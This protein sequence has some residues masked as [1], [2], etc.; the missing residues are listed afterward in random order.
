ML[1]ISGNRYEHT[2]KQQLSKQQ[3]EANIKN[4]FGPDKEA[5]KYFK[6]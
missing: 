4:P 3:S 1:Y 5:I 6:N 2:T